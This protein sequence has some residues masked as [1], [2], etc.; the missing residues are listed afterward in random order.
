MK[1]L[2]GAHDQL[3]FTLIEH[4][5][6]DQFFGEAS[7][8]NSNTLVIIEIKKLHP[9]AIRAHRGKKTTIWA[10]CKILNASFFMSFEYTRFDVSFWGFLD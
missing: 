5:L 8:K 4:K 1:S 7:A 10:D 9:F 3:R 2:L 6:L